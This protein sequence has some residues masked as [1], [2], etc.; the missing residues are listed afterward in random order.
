VK[1]R[2][3]CVQ[4]IRY[5]VAMSLDG[6]IAGPNG[7]ADWIISDPEINFGE[8][9]AQF[10]IGLMGRRTYDSAV[11]RLGTSAF[12][13][14][15]VFVASRTLKALNASEFTIVS[16]L[17][18]ERM[19]EL[20]AQARKDIWLF[21]GG[22][23][24]RALLE[25]GEVDTVEVNVIPLLLGGGLKIVASPAQQTKLKLK[26]HKIYGSGIISLVYDVVK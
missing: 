11:A 7:E 19:Q 5:I 12:K 26:S 15:K 4:K 10:D 25:M 9:W 2:G 21:G 17:S 22:E 13:E 3:L 18:R 1:R 6:Y 20:R 24:F 16:E 14:M 23:L 8:L